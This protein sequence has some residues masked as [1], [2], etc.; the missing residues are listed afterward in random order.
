MTTQFHA[1]QLEHVYFQDRRVHPKA[2]QP[3][4]DLRNIL[5]KRQKPKR[6]L[7]TNE[8]MK[9]GQEQNLMPAVAL[10]SFHL[11]SLILRAVPCTPSSSPKIET[12]KRPRAV[13][14]IRKNIEI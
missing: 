11:C 4:F 10:Y 5:H 1:M 8:A 9:Q 14:K 12:L 7:G 6:N 13:L 3:S 2:A